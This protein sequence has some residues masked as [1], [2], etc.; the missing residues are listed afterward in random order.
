LRIDIQTDGAPGAVPNRTTLAYDFD[1]SE[2]LRPARGPA[3]E[4]LLNQVKDE[5][6]FQVKVEDLEHDDDDDDDNNDD[7]EVEEE[8]E[9][10]DE[11]DGDNDSAADLAPRKRKRTG[12]STG[13]L[14]VSKQ[15]V[16]DYA[17][18]HPS[19]VRPYPCR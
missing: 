3:N 19:Q 17:Q 2:S 16:M 9:V 1:F 10:V 13:H 15:R 14:T 4:E 12:S 18:R 5:Q 8:E 11:V 6:T 7:Y